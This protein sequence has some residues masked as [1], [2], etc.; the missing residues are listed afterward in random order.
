MRAQSSVSNQRYSTLTST[1]STDNYQVGGGLVLS[2]QSSIFI[3]K[4]YPFIIY[5][6]CQLKFIDY[7]WVY[8]WLLFVSICHCNILPHLTCRNVALTCIAAV[9]NNILPH[10][11]PGVII[12]VGTAYD[13]PTDITK[14][15]IKPSILTFQHSLDHG[16]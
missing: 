2:C 13:D 4:F 7:R 6:T 16:T 8:V 5:E 3:T 12:T 11:I 9:A 14:V 10:H 15:R 1:G